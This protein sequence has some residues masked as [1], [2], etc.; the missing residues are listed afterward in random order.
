MNKFY[1][2]AL[3]NATS[4]DVEI[5]LD[6]PEFL[7]MAQIAYANNDWEKAIEIGT[8]WINTNF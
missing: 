7:P 2:L 1:L 3:A 4:V 5:L 8:Q 6:T